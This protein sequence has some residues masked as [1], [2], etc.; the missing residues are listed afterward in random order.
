[1]KNQTRNR[2]KISNKFNKELSDAR[3]KFKN[4]KAEISKEYRAEIKGWRKDLGEET[5]QKLKLEEKLRELVSNSAHHVANFT[6]VRNESS[7]SPA[8]SQPLMDNAENSEETVCSICATPIV[9]YIQKYFQGEPFN[10]ACE[11]CDDDSSIS[12]DC[13]SDVPKLSWTPTDHSNVQHPFTRKGFN[14]NRSTI[15]A[16]NTSSTSSD[17]SHPQQCIIREPFT[18]PFPTL[19]P[20]VNEYSLYHL[21]TMAG[22]LDWGRTCGYCMRIEHEKY[23]CESCIWIKCYGELH[24]YPDIDPYEYKKHL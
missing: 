24:G 6:P 16:S 3:V 13:D 10:P 20:L 9:N 18:P 4:E 17:C 1:M 23:G 8:D 14:S 22:E 5:K 12:D 19:T 7:S 21:K 11:K 15:N 2:K